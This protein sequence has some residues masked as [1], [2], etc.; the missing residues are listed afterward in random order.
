MSRLLVT[1]NAKLLCDIVGLVHGTVEPKCTCKLQ[2]TEQ[3]TK[4]RT[5]CRG[6][7]SGSQG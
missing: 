5:A 3:Q 2:A 7:S 6:V 4:E 1:V